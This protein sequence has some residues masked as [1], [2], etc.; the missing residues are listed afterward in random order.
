MRE[1]GAAERT[2]QIKMSKGR[3][4]WIP[5]QLRTLTAFDWLR[6]SPSWREENSSK[7]PISRLARRGVSDRPRPSGENCQCERRPHT[8]PEHDAGVAAGGIAA[9]S[10]RVSWWIHEPHE[11]RV[12]ALHR[13]SSRRLFD[14]EWAPVGGIAKCPAPR[15]GRRAAA[16]DGRRHQGAVRARATETG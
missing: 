14:V 13:R 6:G 16:D 3:R 10:W 15:R 8:S 7:V 11:R 12:R 9:R 2:H 4:P 5:R 1:N